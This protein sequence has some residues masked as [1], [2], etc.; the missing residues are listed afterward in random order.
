[1]ETPSLAAAGFRYE[2]S[3]D[4][5]R[6]VPV[7]QRTETY[8]PVPHGDMIDWT[9]MAADSERLKVERVDFAN[10]NQGQRMGAYFHIKVPGGDEAG[11]LFLVALLNSYDKSIRA[12]V[13]TGA[14]LFVCSNGMILADHFIRRMHRG[15]TAP[16]T[17]KE[18]IFEAMKA[19]KETIVEAVAL[20]AV[21]LEIYLNEKAQAEL[22]GRLFITEGILNSW[23][24]SELKRQIS[25]PSF[26]YGPFARHTGWEFY[27]HVT[28]ALKNSQPDQFILKQKKLHSF[29]LTLAEDDFDLDMSIFYPPGY[30]EEEG[31]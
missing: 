8:Q 6:A 5:L 25:D 17:I 7:P 13:A 3:E 28:H 22:A 9:Y 2:C 4:F 11:L 31:E 12:S 24:M 20:K 15:E 26:D 27:Q 23:E 19:H 14:T 18:F 10:S 30:L 16:R 29:M 1:M 21:L